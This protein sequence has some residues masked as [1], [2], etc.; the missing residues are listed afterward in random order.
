MKIAFDEHIPPDMVIPVRVLLEKKS[1][2][3]IVLAKDYAEPPA[4]SDVPWLIKFAADQGRVV[5]TG[6]KAMRSRLDEQHALM[7]LGL[8]VFFFPPVWNRWPMTSKCGFLLH[9][10]PA[11]LERAANSKPKQF[12]EL[13]SS[14][15]NVG[16]FKNVSPKS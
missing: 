12:W 8:I 6:D 16:D 4:K 15:S 2:F 13:S 3:E 9:W 14:W 5:I 7:Q 1:H 10:W 11:I